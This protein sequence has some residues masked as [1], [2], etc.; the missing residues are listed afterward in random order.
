[1]G[2]L[3]KAA[4]AI[5]GLTHTPA[6]LS[7]SS[8][9]RIAG[10]KLDEKLAREKTDKKDAPKKKKKRKNTIQKRKGETTMQLVDRMA[11]GQTT[12]DNQ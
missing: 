8:K 7:K 5:V 10:F 9:N 6:E 4:K 3:D 1:M 12:D 2:I 11:R